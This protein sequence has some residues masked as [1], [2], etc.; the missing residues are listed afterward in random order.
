MS[1]VCLVCM[2]FAALERPSLGLGLLQAL[3]EEAG[4]SCRSLYP[5]L[6]WARRLRP[7]RY[8]LWEDT[9]GD[10]VFSWAAFP[11]RKPDCAE[12]IA[13]R[14]GPERR[15]TRRLG[16]PTDRDGLVR[17]A[18]RV[19]QEATAF[20]GEVAL[21]AVGTGARIF[22]CTSMYWQQT[23]S[24][25]LLREIRRLRPDT[26]TM[27]GGTNCEGAMGR[28]LHRLFPWVDYV[29][30]GEADDFFAPWCR[31]LL[32]RGGDAGNLP[33]GVFGPIHRVRGYPVGPAPR[34]TCRNLEAVP[35]PQYRD[36]F[37]ALEA[38][39]LS[40][41]IHPGLPL[42]T[43][44]G[45]WWGQAHQCLFCGISEAGRKFR[46]KSPQRVLAEFDELERRHGLSD[47][48]VL[49]NIMDMHYFRTLLPE[50]EARRSRRRLFW[51]VKSNLRK[52]Q[53]AQLA[54]A[55]I[56]WIQP[57]IEAL[58]S[59]IL[60]LVGKGVLAGQNVLLLKWGRQHGIAV[61]W[62]MLFG[63]PGEE[64]DWYAD[65][66][67]RLPRLLHLQPPRGMI[68]LRMDRY[69]AYQAR[70]EDFGLRLRPARFMSLVYGL[71]E[72]DLEEL[73]YFFQVVDP[74]PKVPGPGVA[75]LFE[76]TEAWRARY[77]RRPAPVLSVEEHGEALFFLDSREE[78]HVRTF[79]LEGELRDTYLRAEDGVPL[80]EAGSGAAVGQLLEMGLLLEIDGRV[81]GL[82]VR[83][84]LPRTP[85]W[86]DFPGG[87]VELAQL[88]KSPVH[89]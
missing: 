69:C 57:G 61:S 53:V 20:V 18:T 22:G 36:Y 12:Y 74:P 9:L 26:I 31:E 49:D 86:R 63:F 24:L 58:D 82:A 83:G 1:E 17:E 28:A 32:E 85:T 29:V 68:R 81:V 67:D 62:N 6:E 37:E 89:S 44:R 47:F 30:S 54:R 11:D 59:R 51:E 7:D 38:S 2:P 79:R 33:E 16:L 35:T 76:A 42:E 52:D 14:L 3:L 84:E 4:I 80:R 60:R 34:A 25:A 72:E 75:R 46:S 78:Q 88:M 43:A 70:A 45:C 21:Q 5:N 48:M 8:S 50:L 13:Q 56:T 77:R 87:H 66:A 40:A 64:D 27:L 19:L 39:P 15:R 65:T 41:G 55:G 71:P 10:L 73:T 23:A